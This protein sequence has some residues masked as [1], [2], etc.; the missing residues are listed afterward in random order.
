MHFCRGGTPPEKVLD[1]EGMHSVGML[2]VFGGGCR[3]G[4]PGG[5]GVD[6]VAT[7]AGDAPTGIIATAVV[8]I[9]S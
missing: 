3:G 9:N 5:G 1:A 4:C 6:E 7:G 8:Q 2:N